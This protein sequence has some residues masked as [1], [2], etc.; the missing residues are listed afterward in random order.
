VVPSSTTPSRAA[1]G[2]S[3]VDNDDSFII[4]DAGHVRQMLIA[5]LILNPTIGVASR[6][7]PVGVVDIFFGVARTRLVTPST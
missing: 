4:L 2:L 7:Q 1:R 5:D 6:L 3:G